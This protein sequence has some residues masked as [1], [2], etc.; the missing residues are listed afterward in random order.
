MDVALTFHW[1]GYQVYMVY[2]MIVTYTSL[3]NKNQHIF[4]HMLLLLL[5]YSGFRNDICF[6]TY[7]LVYELIC[8]QLYESCFWC[9]AYIV[10][11]VTVH[12]DFSARHQTDLSLNLV[13]S[14]VTLVSN[15]SMSVVHVILPCMLWLSHLCQLLCRNLCMSF[16]L[17]VPRWVWI[18]PFLLIT[19]IHLP[20]PSKCWNLSLHRSNPFY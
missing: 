14:T 19:H 6:L 9:L 11:V 17:C 13:I 4:M 16:V 7:V 1:W 10:N 20:L 18:D 12:V 2:C 3:Y 8:M 5:K 15:W